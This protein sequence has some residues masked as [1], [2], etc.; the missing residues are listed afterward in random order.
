MNTCQKCG[1]QLASPQSLWNHRQRCMRYGQSDDIGCKRP[2]DDNGVGP[3][4]PK[5]QALADAIINDKPVYN[6]RPVENA[7]RKSPS[8]QPDEI[9]RKP[10]LQGEVFQKLSSPRPV[11]RKLPSPPQEVVDEVFKLPR[12]KKD[13]VGY[14][15]E[16]D[17]D[18]KSTSNSSDESCSESDDHSSDGSSKE[19]IDDD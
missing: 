8:P 3:S 6:K 11:F 10:P 17:S 15:D 18:K 1:K 7:L 9:F 16:S 2:S 12:T 14:S 13:L 5:L 4:N 19:S